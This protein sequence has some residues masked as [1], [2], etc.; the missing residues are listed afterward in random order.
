MSIQISPTLDFSRSEEGVNVHASESLLSFKEDRKKSELS[1]EVHLEALKAKRK[2][3]LENLELQ[4]QTGLEKR[5]LQNSLLTSSTEWILKT[6]ILQ[7][8]ISGHDGQNS[9]N[10]KHRR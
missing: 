8:S 10:R 4:H 5:V 2:Q 9:K 1:L 7:Q 6:D 3:Y